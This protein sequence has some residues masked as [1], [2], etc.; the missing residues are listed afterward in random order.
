MEGGERMSKEL[1]DALQQIGMLSES[2]AVKKDN[3]VS[4]K[5]KKKLSVNNNNNNKPAHLQHRI[6]IFSSGL[7]SKDQIRRRKGKHRKP[8]AQP[9]T[10]NNN[11]NS[12]T[13]KNSDSD[14]NN[15][16]D[17]DEGF[18]EPMSKI[19]R[20][21]ERRSNSEDDGSEEEEELLKALEMSKLDFEKNIENEDNFE[22]ELSNQCKYRANIYNRQHVYVQL[23][24][25]K[26]PNYC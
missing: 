26:Y 14:E 21:R 23:D 25:D 2:A 7:Y 11:N 18:W 15:K 19:E 17:S 16:S 10:N 13:K 3:P 24:E 8:K 9:A 20:E 5:K 4:I 22:L 1:N 6:N 12:T